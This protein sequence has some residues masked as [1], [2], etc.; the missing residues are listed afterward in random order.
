MQHNDTSALLFQGNW[1][2]SKVWGW[3]FD[4]D[5]NLWFSEAQDLRTAAI[6]GGDAARKGVGGNTEAGGYTFSEWQVSQRFP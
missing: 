1:N 6:F 4:F 2:E 3:Q 5:S